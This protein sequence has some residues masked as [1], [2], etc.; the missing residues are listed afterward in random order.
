MSFV[1]V[2]VLVCVGSEAFHG[3]GEQLT[4]HLSRGIRHDTS[5][6]HERQRGPRPLDKPLAVCDTTAT[7]GHARSAASAAR[8]V[9]NVGPDPWRRSILISRSVK[10]YGSLSRIVAHLNN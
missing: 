3:R 4:D 5:F 6:R 1:V 10:T 8:T 7:N 2:V 9:A